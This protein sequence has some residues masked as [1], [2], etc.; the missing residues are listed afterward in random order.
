[1][2]EYL[3]NLGV[4]VFKSKDDFEGFM[5]KKD[6][7]T[8]LMLV[9]ETVAVMRC[10]FHLYQ[11]DD[12]TDIGDHFPP[13][14]RSGIRECAEGARKALKNNAKKYKIKN[15]KEVKIY[16]HPAYNSILYI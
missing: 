10:N 7:N 2:I 5:A 8:F 16:L 14:E 6:K 12:Y 1:M 3:E 15:P 4:H 13:F 9:P 11:N